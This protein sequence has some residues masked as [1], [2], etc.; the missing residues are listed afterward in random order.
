MIF[1]A[2][3]G[4]HFIEEILPKKGH[5][6]SIQGGQ[7]TMNFF[8]KSSNIHFYHKYDAKTVHIC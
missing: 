4:F 7:V 1:C 2:T 8:S 3:L 6:F 5:F